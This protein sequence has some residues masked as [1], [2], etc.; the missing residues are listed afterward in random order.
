MVGTLPV[1]A[2]ISSSLTVTESPRIPAT[3]QKLLVTG[4]SSQVFQV[5]ATLAR[6]TSGR[7]GI[8]LSSRNR[9]SRYCQ[10]ETPNLRQVFFS[11]TK[12]SLA[13]R[14][15]SERVPPLILGDF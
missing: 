9:E 12:V 15:A 1:S 11:P 2:K 4:T 10:N 3:A 8:C 7:G 6:I 13:R 14:P 5:A